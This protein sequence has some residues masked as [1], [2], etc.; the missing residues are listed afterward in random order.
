MSQMETTGGD[1]PPIADEIPVFALTA[2]PTERV[3]SVRGVDAT[4][5]VS[6]PTGRA[7]DVQ[8]VLEAEGKDL[9][10]QPVAEG[11]TMGT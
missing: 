1:T 11:I 9:F 6:G 7:I 3:A 10:C 4:N 2:T 5:V 8:V